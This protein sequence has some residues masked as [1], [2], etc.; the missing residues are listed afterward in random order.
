MD[1]KK[2]SQMAALSKERE[3]LQSTIQ[4]YRT[5]FQTQRTLVE[6]LRTSVHE[7]AREEQSIRAELRKQNIPGAQLQDTD[8]VEKL[9]TARM[10]ERDQLLHKPRRLCGLAPAPDEPDVI[11]KAQ[12]IYSKTQGRQ[13][14]LPLD[15]IYRKN[16][17]D[18]GKPLPHVRY[19]PNW[20]PPGRPVYARDMLQFHTDQESCRLVF[21]MLLG[22]TLILDS[23]DHANAYRQEIIKHSHCPTILTWQ[24]DRIRSNGKFGGTMNKAVPIE[25]LRGAVFGEPLP[26][27]YHA[28]CTQIA[29]LEQYQAAL[30]RHVQA[31]D[32]LQEVIN[33]QKNPEMS[34]K[35]K[36]CQEAE[37][38]LVEI[39]RQLGG[40]P[41]SPIVSHRTPL[42]GSIG[43]AAEPDPSITPT[44]TSLR[45][46]SMTTVVSDDGRKRLRKT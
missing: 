31:Q 42:N 15:S 33:T 22:D 10:K 1:A 11:G 41:T 39:E 37:A 38:Q 46:A 35:Y 28:L 27:A 25:K 45:I 24:G 36:E 14:V 4:A 7:A 21:G 8:S 19:R 26:M 16:L 29:S 20:K 17:P 5:M 12:E 3:N 13:Q 30:T 18:W 2:Q 9:I 6:E 40:S 32:E 23:L 34:A 44:R 43:D